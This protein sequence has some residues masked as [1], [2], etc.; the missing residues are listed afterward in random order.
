MVQDIVVADPAVD[1]APA[2]SQLVRVGTTAVAIGWVYSGG[3]FSRTIPAAELAAS[4]AAEDAAA[5][6][7]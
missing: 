6:G 4:I 7:S 1:V 5:N 3:E 2:G